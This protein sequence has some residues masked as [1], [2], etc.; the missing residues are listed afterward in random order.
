MSQSGTNS[1]TN[2]C[3]WHCSVGICPL[4]QDMNFVSLHNQRGVSSGCPRN[5]CRVYAP[6]NLLTGPRLNSIHSRAEIPASQQLS[7]AISE[8]FMEGN[9][10][11][12]PKLVISTKR[13][14]RVH[15]CVLVKKESDL[16]GAA[17]G[18]QQLGGVTHGSGAVAEGRGELGRLAEI[19]LLVLG[20]LVN[21]SW[22]THGKRFR[23]PPGHPRALRVS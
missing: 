6:N 3:G 1:S 8:A 9:E 17:H 15:V 11:E 21:D 12:M 4:C 23:S 5:A 2:T 16:G 14:Q 7:L 22:R 13:T 18:A 10:K 20:R 19:V